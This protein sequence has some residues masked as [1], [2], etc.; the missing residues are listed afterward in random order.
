MASIYEDDYN[1]EDVGGDL[2]DRDQEIVDR[3]YRKQEATKDRRIENQRAEISRLTQ[4]VD[5]LKKA[6]SAKDDEIVRMRAVLECFRWIPVA[7][8]MPCDTARVLLSDG[9]SVCEAYGES[10]KLHPQLVTHWM[11]LPHAP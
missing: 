5:E 8:R 4:R 6:L 2:A 3:F 1:G 7:E 10:A 9:S 11:P